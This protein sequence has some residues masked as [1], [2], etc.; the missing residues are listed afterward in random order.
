ML[1][2][3]LS[4]PTFGA[5]EQR[6]ERQALSPAYYFGFGAS[7][8][9]LW[10]LATTTGALMGNLI[11][12]PHALGMD[13]LLSL[14]FLSLLMGFRARANWLTV[15][16]ASGLVSAL[17]F[18]TIGSPW[19]IIFGAIVGILLAAIIGKPASDTGSLSG[20]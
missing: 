19:H 14:Y 6:A 13:M 20:D 2:S 18:K 5:G 7:I 4:D 9:P 3:F 1:G 12:N 10:L 16:L 17:V 8:Y 11:T 15:V